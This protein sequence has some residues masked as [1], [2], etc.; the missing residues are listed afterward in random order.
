MSADM[1]KLMVKSNNIKSQA[2]ISPH[3]RRDTI[4]GTNPKLNIIQVNKLTTSSD[5]LNEIVH[6]KLVEEIKIDVPKGKITNVCFRSQAGKNEMGQIK[7]NQDNYVVLERIFDM[8]SFNIFGVLD[9]HGI[10]H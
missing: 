5:R 1:T 4:A 8:D 2:V 3:R 7:T 10:I 9:G 6:P